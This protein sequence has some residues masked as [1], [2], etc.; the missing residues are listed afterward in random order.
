MTQSRPLIRRQCGYTLIE[1]MVVVAIMGL[2][3]SVVLPYL[4]GD[5]QE[6]L[7][8]ELDRFEARIAF[9][10]THAVLQSQDLGLAVDEGEYRFMARG[11]SG[12]QVM[13]DES[14]K[15]Q[16]IPDFLQQHL[17]IEDQEYFAEESAD[18]EVV[19][20]KVIFFSSGEITPFKYQLALSEYNY[21]SLEYDP[22]GE[23]KRESLNETE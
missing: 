20:P 11:A 13:D 10:Q 23:V 2:L 18:D 12:W 19:A 21:S 4:P 8:E 5:K 22:L 7:Y 14:L 1:I 17:F 3:T 6:L 9:A 16:K 15:V